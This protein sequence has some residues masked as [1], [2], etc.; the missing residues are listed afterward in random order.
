MNP[1]LVSTFDI[2]Y[3]GSVLGSIFNFSFKKNKDD[4]CFISASNIFQI[5]GPKYE[6]VSKPFHTVFADG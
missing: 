4:F 5:F 2:F 1:T 3:M 6:I